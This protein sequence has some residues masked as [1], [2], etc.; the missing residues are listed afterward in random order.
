MKSTEIRSQIVTILFNIL[1]SNRESDPYL[2]IPATDSKRYLFIGGVSATI[3]RLGWQMKI[4]YLIDIETN[5][6]NNETINFFSIYLS[7]YF[8]F[9]GVPKVIR[10]DKDLVCCHESTTVILKLSTHTE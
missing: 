10:N 1:G 5:H 3:Y 2:L 9:I 6:W 4:L 7:L 8:G